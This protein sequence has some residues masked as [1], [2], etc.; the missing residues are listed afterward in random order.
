[1]QREGF[2]ISPDGRI[3]AIEETHIKYICANPSE[4]CLTTEHIREVF[5]RYNESFGSEGEA[6]EELVIDAVK[7]DW[8]RIRH[9]VTPVDYWSFN[10]N[11]FV[12][13]IMRIKKL[14]ELVISYRGA[15][16]YSQVRIEEFGGDKQVINADFDN[17]IKS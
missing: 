11:T 13:S 8:I 9:Y 6:R 16:R 1:M 17:V 12:S 2:W 4:F 5:E 14:A 3:V 7:G 15:G 10:V